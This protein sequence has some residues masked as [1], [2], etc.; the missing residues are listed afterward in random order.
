MKVLALALVGSLLF[1]SC[2]TPSRSGPPEAPPKTVRSIII[3]GNTYIHDQAIRRHVGLQPG[4]PLD[5]AEFERTL[6]R[7]DELRYFPDGQPLSQVRMKLLAVPGEPDLVDVEIRLTEANK[8][9][10]VWG[11]GVSSDTGVQG[12]FQFSKRNS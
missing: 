6:Q 4:K 12:T 1:L 2:S 3:T 11:M 5:M 8:G 7:L 10:F 9:T